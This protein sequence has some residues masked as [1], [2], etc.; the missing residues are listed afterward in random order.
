MLKIYKAIFVDN[1]ENFY[2]RYVLANSR[3]EV[4]ACYTDTLLWAVPTKIKANEFWN[5]I[6]E[7]EKTQII[8]SFLKSL[9]E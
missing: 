8:S 2:A 5:T 1:N 7:T 9:E 6:S 3:K 4:S